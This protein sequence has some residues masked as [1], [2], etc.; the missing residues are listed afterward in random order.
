MKF[1]RVCVEDD[2]KMLGLQPECN[3]QC[4]GLS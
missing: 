2:M 4:S 1:W 3:G